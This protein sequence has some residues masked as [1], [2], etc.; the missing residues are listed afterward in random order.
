MMDEKPEKQIWTE[1]TLESLDMSDTYQ[2]QIEGTE[3]SGIEI[4]LRS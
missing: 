2:G 3:G 4:E 1:P